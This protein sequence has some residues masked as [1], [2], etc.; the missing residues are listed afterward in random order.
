MTEQNTSAHRFAAAGNTIIDAADM[1]IAGASDGAL[2]GKGIF[3][4]I[5]IYGGKPYLWEKHWR[6]LTTNAAKME[7]DLSGFTEQSAADAL[8]ELIETNK[9]SRGRARM[10]FVDE[11]AGAI[12]NFG[13]KKGTNLIILTADPRKAAPAPMLTISPYMINTASPLAGVKS[14]NYMENILAMTEARGR[15]FDESIR[16]NER[17]EAASACLANIFWLKNKKLFTPSLKTG[18]LPGTTRE[19]VLENLAC[20]EVENG[21]EE[22]QMADEIFLTSAGIGV[23]QA[24][25]FDGRKLARDSHQILEIITRKFETA[26]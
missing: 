18:C 6:R 25:E 12:W 11:S 8:T 7:I 3:T 22:L 24:S 5:A 19:F 1:R 20:E 4:T 21:I 13:E 16:V 17:G 26:D 2:Y 14:L 9:V 15:L 10:S 23:V